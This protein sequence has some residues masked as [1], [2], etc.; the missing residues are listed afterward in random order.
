[1]T[2]EDVTTLFAEASGL[3]AAIVVQPTDTDLHEL[4]KFLLPILPD[5]PYDLEEGKQN[6]V[7]I[8]SDDTDYNTD[9]GISFV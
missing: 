3:F 4:R 7:G 2:L 6:L 1:M 5:I 8:I 9:Y